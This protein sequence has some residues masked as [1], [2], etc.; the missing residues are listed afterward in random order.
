MHTL[1]NQIG[2]APSGRIEALPESVPGGSTHD[3]TL[4]RQT[5]WLSEL[6]DEEAAMMDKGYDGITADYPDKKLYLPFKARRNHPLTEEQKAYNRF[7]AKYRIVVEHTIAQLNKLGAGPAL[8]PSIVEAL[9]HFP[10]C[11]CFG[12]PPYLIAPFE[13]I[14]HRLAK[15][16]PGSV[17]TCLSYYCTTNLIYI[18][19]ARCR[20]L[21][22]AYIE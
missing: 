21:S 12:Q 1:K 6:D 14:C 9:C 11:R 2:V 4:L 10:H 5:D 8:P 18:C 19:L 13:A 15:L 20:V 16:Q 22:F 7:L 17:K 3:L